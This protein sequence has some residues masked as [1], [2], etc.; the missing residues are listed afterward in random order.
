METINTAQEY[1][2]AISTIELSWAELVC[3]CE[4]T[5]KHAIW[6]TAGGWCA[7]SSG[8][9]RHHSYLFANLFLHLDR[10]AQLSH[11]LHPV[12]GE[13]SIFPQHVVL[14]VGASNERRPV[15]GT[16]C[17][18]RKGRY[19][20]EAKKQHKV[21]VFTSYSTVQVLKII[22]MLSLFVN[23][24]LVSCIV[25]F[26]LVLNFSCVEKASAFGSLHLYLIF[27]VAVFLLF[28]VPLFCPHLLLVTH[29]ITCVAAFVF[30]CYFTTVS[31]LASE[32]TEP[33][34]APGHYMCF[35]S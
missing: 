12:T 23:C 9:P 32:L 26:N 5:L 19:T 13:A 20:L 2:R 33:W 31:Q 25:V 27:P 28:V 1:H 16:S 22:V 11:L 14:R 7:K 8:V 34:M 30:L 15:V 18:N 3:E 21:L 17:N 29:L 35:L 10:R 24:F 4:L 6:S